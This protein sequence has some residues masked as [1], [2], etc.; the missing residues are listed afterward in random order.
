MRWCLAVEVF[1]GISKCLNNRYLFLCNEAH[2]CKVSGVFQNYY[3]QASAA[4]KKNVSLTHF[5]PLVSSIQITDNTAQKI[6]F[7]IKYFFNKCDQI[8]R[9]DL[10]TFTEEILNGKLHFLRSVKKIFTARLF[11]YLSIYSCLFI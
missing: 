10:I 2:A 7:S 4:D 9:E 3:F 1:L 6:K 8:R 5:I 11:T